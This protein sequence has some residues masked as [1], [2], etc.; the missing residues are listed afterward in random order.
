ML[1][2][3]ISVKNTLCPANKQFVLRHESR[4]ISG[5][6]AR[7]RCQFRCVSSFTLFILCSIISQISWYVWPFCIL[8]YNTV[9]CS[10]NC[11]YNRW[12]S[13]ERRA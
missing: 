10:V 5:S 9:R 13:R 3:R 8:K 2:F 11:I 12:A 1:M 7:C 6:T 4:A